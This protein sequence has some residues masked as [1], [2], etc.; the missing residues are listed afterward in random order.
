MRKQEHLLLE[1]FVVHLI[2]DRLIPALP[3]EAVLQKAAAHLEAVLNQALAQNLVLVPV[4]VQ[5]PHMIMNGIEFYRTMIKAIT[6]Y[7][8]YTVKKV[9]LPLIH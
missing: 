6:K 2:V 7:V 1:E 5:R 9:K 4:L 8:K 3:Q